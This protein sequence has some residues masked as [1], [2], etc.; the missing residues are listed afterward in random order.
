MNGVNN[1]NMALFS[2]N[3]KIY[4]TFRRYKYYFHNAIQLLSL[5]IIES[6]TVEPQ[7][8]GALHKKR[9]YQMHKY[10]ILIPGMLYQV[11][12]TEATVIV[13]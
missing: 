3:P 6:G 7:S 2:V 9:Y 10:A 4:S 5:G 12:S 1:Q 11:V 8:L 13:I